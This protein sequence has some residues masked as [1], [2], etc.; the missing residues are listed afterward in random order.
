M[1][2]FHKHRWGLHIP[3]TTR[4]HY[5]TKIKEMESLLKSKMRIDNEALNEII[6]PRDINFKEAKTEFHSDMN[7]DD[8][9]SDDFCS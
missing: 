2:F 5:Y 7:T 6:R 1:Q 8:I 3:E 4:N 9:N